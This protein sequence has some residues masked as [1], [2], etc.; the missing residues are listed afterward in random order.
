VT[1]Q[2]NALAWVILGRFGARRHRRERDGHLIEFGA[3]RAVTGIGRREQGQ[4]LFAQAPDGPGRLPAGQPQ[5]ASERVGRREPAKCRCRYLR[6]AP[7]GL[8]GAVGL[9]SPRDRD[10]RP[11]PVGETPDHALAKPYRMPA[12]AQ[13]LQRAVPLGPIDVHGPD[14]DSML[15]RVSHELGWCV[16]GCRAT[17]TRYGRALTRSRRASFAY[18]SGRSPTEA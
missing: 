17:T 6:L 11:V 12:A 8:D 2:V 16:E 5:R 1:S 14:L 7:E 4:W 10:P 3:E 9:P 15:D 13:R 18:P